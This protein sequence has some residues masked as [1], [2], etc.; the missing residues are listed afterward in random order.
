MSRLLSFLCGALLAATPVLAL[1]SPKLGKWGVDLTSLDRS[2]KP[3]DDFFLYVNGGWLKTAQIPP[4]RASGGLVPGPADPQR[5]AAEDHR[6][7]SGKDAGGKAGAGR[8]EAARSLRR[9]RRHRVH[10]SQGPAAGA[11]G[12]GL[13]CRPQDAGRCRPCHGFGAALHHERLQ[14]RHRGGRQE[15][16]QL[17]GQSG[18]GGPGPARPR[19]LP[20]RAT[21]RSSKPA[22]PI[23]N[24]SPT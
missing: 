2:L 22:S 5:G 13:S 3:G 23:A 21:R 11:E 8:K 24:I 1:D 18:P 20:V 4:D 6:R 14:Y 19:L 12:P 10:R 9:L 16:Q 17:F 7:R 15:S